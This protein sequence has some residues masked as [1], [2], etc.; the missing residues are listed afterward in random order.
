[1]NKQQIRGIVGNAIIIGIL[2]LFLGIY[3]PSI[4]HAIEFAICLFI[5]YFVG[6]WVGQ[7]IDRHKK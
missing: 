4:L 6:A 5:T 2:S 3:H 1:M 7:S